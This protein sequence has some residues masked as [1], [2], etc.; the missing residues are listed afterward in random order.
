MRASDIGT[1]AGEHTAR[2]AEL[3]QKDLRGVHAAACLFGAAVRTKLCECNTKVLTQRPERGCKRG[4]LL[5]AS[6]VVDPCTC[7]HNRHS[8]RNLAQKVAGDRMLT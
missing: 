8:I 3:S 1:R 6:V 7:A 4:A 5:A 2:A